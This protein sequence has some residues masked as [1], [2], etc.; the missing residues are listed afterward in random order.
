MDEIIV[1]LEESTLHITLNRPEHGNGV[2]DTMAIEL[3]RLIDTAHERADFVVLRGAGPDFCTGRWVTGGP[4]GPVQGGHM[5]LELWRHPDDP[6]GQE[7]DALTIECTES[8]Q[9]IVG[10][11]GPADGF[12][13]ECGHDGQ[14][15]DRV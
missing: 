9:P 5:G 2:S 7:F 13:L 10:G 14:R 11:D 1:V 8:R 3:T 6:P 15:L 4:G 12:G